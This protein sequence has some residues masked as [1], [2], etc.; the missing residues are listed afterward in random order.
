M[1]PRAE[2]LNQSIVAQLMIEGNWR[3]RARKPSPMGEK[4]STM[5]KF[6]RIT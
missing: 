3:Q 2:R 6:S 5:C 1:N 4:A